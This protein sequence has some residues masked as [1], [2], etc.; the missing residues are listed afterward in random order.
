MAE[1]PGRLEHVRQFINTLD[2]E[3]G[4]EQLDSPQALR[5][6]LQEHDLLPPCE[7][8]F[9]AAA[10]AHHLDLRETLRALALANGR[11]AVDAAAMAHL[12]ELAHD[13]PLRLTFGEEV[14]LVP[15][16]DLRS[17]GGA[18]ILGAVHQAMLDGS[19]SRLKACACETC[20]FA[21]YDESRNRSGTW[22]DMAVC[23]NRTKVRTYRKRQTAAS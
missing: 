16:C 14:G 15:A 1:A 8:A 11:G 6:W 13:S 5:Q 20:A 10:L 22:C 3:T 9:D 18:A 7:V 19:W 12:N 23:G 4:R 17:A 2:V 21:F